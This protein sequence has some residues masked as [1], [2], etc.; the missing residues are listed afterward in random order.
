[1]TKEEIF[2]RFEK[3][4]VNLSD[5]FKPSDEEAV[6]KLIR[7]GELHLVI[8]ETD[9]IQEFDFVTAEELGPCA[10]AYSTDGGEWDWRPGPEY[11]PGTAY[12]FFYEISPALAYVWLERNKERKIICVK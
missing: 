9:P 1:M 7:D 4:G 3:L 2:S 5:Y 6:M 10:I 11:V 12:R 8:V